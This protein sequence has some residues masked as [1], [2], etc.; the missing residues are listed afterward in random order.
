MKIKRINEAY[1]VLH[2]AKRRKTYE[3]LGK[4][5]LQFGSNIST[6]DMFTSFFGSSFGRGK[7]NPPPPPKPQPKPYP[8][9]PD[10]IAC[11]TKVKIFGLKSAMDH[12]GKSQ[13]VLPPPP[14]PSCTKL[15][16]WY[17]YKR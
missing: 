9:Q 10:V 3:Q 14:S 15:I 5:G 2:D 11:G 16:L 1:E 12:N 8:K 7:P 13:R 4:H 6:D 17:V